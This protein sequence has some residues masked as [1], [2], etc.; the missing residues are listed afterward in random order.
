VE[1]GKAFIKYLRDCQSC[2]LCELE[3]S[4]EAIHVNPYRERRAILPW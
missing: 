4:K 1:E 3:C 2:F